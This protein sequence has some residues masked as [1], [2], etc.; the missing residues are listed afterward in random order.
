MG[1]AG[2]WGDT[3]D[4]EQVLAALRKLNETGSIFDDI[5]IWVDGQ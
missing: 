1:I 4:E 3:M 2:S 5:T